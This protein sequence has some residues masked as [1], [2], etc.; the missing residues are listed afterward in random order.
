MIEDLSIVGHFAILDMV[1]HFLDLLMQG[2]C[3][4]TCIKPIRTFSFSFFWIIKED[5]G[6]V[7]RQKTSKWSTVEFVVHIGL[8]VDDMTSKLYVLHLHTSEQ[9]RPCE[10]RTGGKINV[11]SLTTKLVIV[12]FESVDTKFLTELVFSRD[13]LFPFF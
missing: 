7:W 1:C 6:F 12:L 10:K 3:I 8:G 2:F 9:E 13:I 11:L 4:R 5:V